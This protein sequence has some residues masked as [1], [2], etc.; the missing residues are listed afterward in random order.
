M[1]NTVS[2]CHPLWV[3]LGVLT[4]ASIMFADETYNNTY[5][6]NIYIILSMCIKD[7]YYMDVNCIITHLLESRIVHYSKQLLEFINVEGFP[8]V[9]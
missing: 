2:K 5:N 6:T 1:K 9:E 8:Y 7:K 3:L 4:D